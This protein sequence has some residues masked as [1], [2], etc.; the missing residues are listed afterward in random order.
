MGAN[1]QCPFAREFCIMMPMQYFHFSKGP[2]KTAGTRKQWWSFVECWSVLPIETHRRSSKSIT[3]R[4]WK[5]LMV[6]GARPKSLCIWL[7]VF[8]CDQ[9]YGFSHCNRHSPSTWSSARVQEIHGCD[10]RAPLIEFHH[11]SFQRPLRL[12]QR[13]GS[14]E[15]VA[16]T[17][18]RH[19][20]SSWAPIFT[21]VDRRL[22]RPVYP[23]C[24]GEGHV[25]LQLWSK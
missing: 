14:R 13:G 6:L 4:Q 11:A 5:L 9:T 8:F 2:K 22:R 18:L 10:Q 21:N 3:V 12:E 16:S 25:D 17:S 24:E 20:C 15:V 19:P 23:S 7:A 1:R